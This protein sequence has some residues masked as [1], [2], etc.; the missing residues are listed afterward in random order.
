MGR[1]SPHGVIVLGHG[2]RLPSGLEVVEKTCDRVAR[3]LG[4]GAR[5]RPAYMELAEPGMDQ[6]VADLLAE[7]PLESCTIVPL[8]LTAG[9]HVRHQIPRMVQDLEAAY[10]QVA[11]RL[12]DHIGP[13]PLLG[14]LVL[15][16]IG[17][18]PQE[19]I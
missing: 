13:D 4:S 1:I 17:H 8:F 14:D 5:V 9:R 3:V 16:R 6:V 15:A 19:G 2:S 12:T 11:F 18:R 10:P 7:G